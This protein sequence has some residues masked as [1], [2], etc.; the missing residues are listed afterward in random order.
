MD[1]QEMIAVMIDG[2]WSAWECCGRYSISDA[3]A[4]A[5]A[6][7]YGGDVLRTLTTARQ[8]FAA[9][10]AAEDQQALNPDYWDA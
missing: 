7:R 1:K 5:T 9:E 2:L 6:R 4:D 10:I 8:L 3:T